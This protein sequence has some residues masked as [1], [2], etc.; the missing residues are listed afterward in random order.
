[1]LRFMTFLPYLSG[2][3][4]AGQSGPSRR[5]FAFACTMAIGLLSCH[6]AA[7][8]DAILI[9][10]P[11]LAQPATGPLA[12]VA[13]RLAHGAPLTIVAF[14]SSS[15]EGVGA[16]SPA[17]A[18]PARLQADLAAQVPSTETITV[19]NRGIGGEDADDMLVRL[20]RDVIGARPD[21]V[22]WQTGTNDPLR[23]LPIDRFEAETRAGIARMRAAGI[24]VVL[25]EPQDCRM[26]RATPGAFTYLDA[27]RRIGQDMAV[28]VVRR[29]DMIHRWLADGSVTE[30]QLMAPDGLHMA[31]EG[32]ERLAKEVAHELLAAA[33]RLPVVVKASAR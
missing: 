28:P 26:M 30:A 6:S 17:H 13:A 8:A 27:V 11:P 25:M 22:I 31:D 14:G 7:A 2:G 24:D 19:I 10:T 20:Q 15:T 3:W 5:F 18:Y 32:Y 1:M 33:G 16:S 9:A 12:H 23:K 29:Y 21:L 4:S